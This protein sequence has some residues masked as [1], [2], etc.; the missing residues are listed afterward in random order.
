MIDDA[1]LDQDGPAARSTTRGFVGFADQSELERCWDRR[2]PVLRVDRRGDGAARGPEGAPLARELG[3]DLRQP[4]AAARAVVR[5]LDAEL[6]DAS[7]EVR[8]RVVQLEHQLELLSATVGSILEPAP[9]RLVGLVA[10]C[11]DCCASADAGAPA[12]VELLVEA[13]PVVVGDA[14]ELHRVVVNLL[15]NARRAAGPHGRVRLRVA[16]EAG[17]ALLE[18]DD[19][20][21]QEAS[22]PEVPS[23]GLGLLIVSGIVRRHG[24]VVE[25]TESDLGGLRISVRLPAALP[26]QETGGPA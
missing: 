15:V 21:G 12:P 7:V 22:D 18:V 23:T 6:Q 20:G 19:A 17:S 5:S 3:H 14:A 25:T 2:D 16:G 8:R 26:L 11:R 24:G 13:S 4:I 10:V 9:P 1:R